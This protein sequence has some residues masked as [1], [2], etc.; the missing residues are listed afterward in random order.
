M[1][2]LNNDTTAKTIVI[3]GD[4]QNIFEGYSADKNF[5]KE[6]LGD[7]KGKEEKLKELTTKL[8][9]LE[10]EFVG[11]VGTS[12]LP[13]FKV[14]Y[15]K[16]KNLKES[17]AEN[18]NNF[19]KESGDNYVISLDRNY[20]RSEDIEEKNSEKLIFLDCT[21]IEGS[22]EL[23]NRPG[24][25]TLEEQFKKIAEN[26]PKRANIAIADDVLFS[27]NT[28]KIIMEKIKSEMKKLD[29]RFI[30]KKCVAVV[31]VKDKLIPENL[32]SIEVEAC[33]EYSIESKRD[34]MA[35]EDEICSRDFVFGFPQTGK[36]S[37]DEK[38]TMPY[39]LPFGNINNASIPN[40]KQA[41]FS[42][43]CIKYNI[44]LYEEVEK[45]TSKKTKLSDL[46]KMPYKPYIPENL[47]VSE[48]E[49]VL[50]LLSKALDLIDKRG[51]E[52]LGGFVNKNE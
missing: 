43:I 25:L 29:K 44:K 20:I 9:E 49:T 42:K 3:S 37:K 22:N 32:D 52:K 24:T 51:E 39:F 45:F 15:L 2:T 33:K 14:Q 50:D 5:L 21:R 36:L 47:S 27:G 31:C 34:P 18:I 11:E 46:K 1:E 6:L 38:L 8:C 19:L 30:F 48:D 13:D 4:I 10:K 12:L 16:D 35:I 7:L 26:L 40:E 17:F 28:I 41:K 23:T